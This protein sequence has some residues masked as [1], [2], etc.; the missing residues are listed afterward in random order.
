MYVT[1]FLDSWV[2]VCQNLKPQ[3]QWTMQYT[4][5]STAVAGNP[6]CF[7]LTVQKNYVSNYHCF[8]KHQH[9]NFY[10]I[11]KKTM[12]TRII[13]NLKILRRSRDDEPIKSEETSGIEP[14][15]SKE[16]RMPTCKSLPYVDCN[17]SIGWSWLKHIF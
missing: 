13:K 2:E 1:A 12:E 14:I 3:T 8:I 17:V 7:Q 16:T 4:L 15:K 11:R 6:I 10:S 9:H 5:C